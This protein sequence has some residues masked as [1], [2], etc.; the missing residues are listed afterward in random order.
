MIL[1]KS[2]LAEHQHVFLIRPNRSMSAAGMWL[3][4]FFVSLAVLLL[5][6]RFYLV[7]A[8]V[9]LPFALLEVGALVLGFWLFDRS[10]RHN[11]RLQLSRSKFLIV[12]D[13][14]A[15]S[16]EWRFHPNWVKIELCQDPNDWYPSRLVIASRGQQV[17]V[18]GCLT[19]LERKELSEALIKTMPLVLSDAV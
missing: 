17:E 10:S 18:G 8:W 15:G 6:F 16:T 7:G 13:G 5:A 11:E 9:V 14:V 1:E 19:D 2:D 4:V 3:F 12:Q